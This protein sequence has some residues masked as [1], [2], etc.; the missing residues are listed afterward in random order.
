[1]KPDML[2]IM[3]TNRKIA[4]ISA[5]LILVNIA[6][7][8]LSLFKE[9]LVARAFGVSKSMDAF[10]AAMS[11]PGFMSSIL[12]SVLAATFIPL[13]IRTKMKDRP[14]ADKLASAVFNWIVLL[15]FAATVMLTLLSGPIMTLLFHGLEPEAHALAVKILRLLWW[16][17]FL[18]VPIGLA[19]GLLN[20]LE[21]F[22]WPVISQSFIT[23]ATIF[24]VLFF[25]PRL[26]IYTVIFGLLGGL[27]LQLAFLRRQLL[28][29]GFVYSLSLRG[30][31]DE[32]KGLAG[33]ALVFTAGMLAA[34]I[35]P[36]VDQM[37]ASWLAPGSVAALG[38]AGKLIQVPMVIFSSSI[39]TAVFP[40]FARQLEENKPEELKYSLARSVRTVGFVYIPFSL[41]AVIFA[42]PVIALLFQR[43]HF[44]AAATNLVAAT[45]IFF[46][47]QLFFHTSNIICSR[48][49]FALKDMWTMTRFALLTV[50]LNAA[51][52]LLFIRFFSPPVAGI[53]LSTCVC[54][55]VTSLLFFMHLRKRLGGLM[56]HYMLKGLALNFIVA[57]AAAGT[58][59]VLL[60]LLSANGVSAALASLTAGLAVYG[61]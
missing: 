9:M 43:G 13:Y 35:N 24:L 11:V 26:G 60:D 15:F 34:Q 1:M 19:T 55:A 42:K 29:A 12:L 17:A 16:S 10:Y 40:Y 38:Y 48:V 51:L 57:L 44:D 20:A 6:G 28:K 18:S 25:L 14:A 5:V 39:I 58:A 41:F 3:T 27:A 7:H 47:F 50:L 31:W 52:N 32:M 46:S 45:F 2:V 36:V 54:H 4:K 23:L 37:M 59:R 33:L 30:G 61:G 53:A 22:A 8:A 56:G 21:N 49:F